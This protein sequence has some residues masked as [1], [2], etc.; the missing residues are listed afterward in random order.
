MDIADRIQT[1]AILV[2]LL[3]LLYQLRRE[4]LLHSADMVTSLVA[5]FSSEDFEKASKAFG[6]SSRADNH[7]T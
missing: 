6:C 4:W 5:Q 2:S 1:G 3:G 7:R